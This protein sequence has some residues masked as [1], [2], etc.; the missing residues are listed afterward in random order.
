MNWFDVLIIIFCIAIVVFA[1]IK[2]V[3][4]KK[5]GKTSCGCN[6]ANCKNNACKSKLTNKKQ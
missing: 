5:N 3:I 4:D 1:I 6:C 2:A